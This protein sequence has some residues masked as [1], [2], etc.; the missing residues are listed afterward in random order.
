MGNMVTILKDSNTE[1]HARCYISNKNSYTNTPCAISA[2]LHEKK[3]D[4]YFV[5]RQ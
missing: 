2:K 4:L 5:F 3:E 1:K